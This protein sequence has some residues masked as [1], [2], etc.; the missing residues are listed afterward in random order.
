MTTVV[1]L[2]YTIGMHQLEFDYYTVVNLEDMEGG[3]VREFV[4]G[5]ERG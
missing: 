1:F 5:M 3:I 2:F 4:D